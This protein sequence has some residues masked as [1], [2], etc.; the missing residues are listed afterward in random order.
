[1]DPA[2]DCPATGNECVVA[3]C[4]GGVCGQENVAQG[5]PLASQPVGGCNEVQ[6]DG[7]GGTVEVPLAEQ[8]PCTEGGGEL[9]NGAGVCVECLSG[10]DCASGVCG[11]ANLCVSCGAIDVPASPP[12]CQSGAPGAGSNCGTSG[13]VSCC[14]NKLVP[15]G[16]YKRSYDGVNYTDASNT[17]TVSYFRLDTY[18]LTVGRFRAF[19]NAGQGTQA[20]PPGAGAGEHPKI[21]GSGWDPR[22]NGNLAA[23]VAELKSG[24]H[25]DGTFGTWT[26]LPGGSEK[27]P[28]NCIDWYQAFAFC[29]WDGG[30]LPTEAEWNY[31]AAGG[32]EQREYPWGSGVDGTRAVY[33]CTDDGSP[34]CAFSDILPVG[35]KSP[36]GDGLWGQADLA[37][38]MWEWTRDGY[39]DYLS[40]CND[41]AGASAPGR[42]IRGGSF[43]GD[44]SFLH[45][46]FRNYDVPTDRSNVIG[47]RCARTR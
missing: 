37:G 6:C 38:S 47:A 42:V 43:G 14:E 13:N 8:T 41:C 18:E 15:C 25:C 45:A 24:L 29:A 10:V 4:E 20:S 22:W 21:P 28:I 7:N 23:D 33:G 5:T 1:M 16:T 40:N 17:A 9:C 12:S 27:L 46:A 11:N 31:A 35:S 2:A 3:V 30:R 32:A 34:G 36:N 19:V 39:D 44:A 26:D